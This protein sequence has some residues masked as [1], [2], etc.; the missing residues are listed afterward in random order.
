MSVE[1]WLIILF[2]ILAFGGVICWAVEKA[3]TPKPSKKPVTIQ[4]PAYVPRH[5]AK[6]REKVYFELRRWQDRFDALVGSTEAEREHAEAVVK[7]MNLDLD[8]RLAVD[9]L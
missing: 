9:K 5:N 2:W 1:A 7:H 6:T 8:L 4:E 3:Q